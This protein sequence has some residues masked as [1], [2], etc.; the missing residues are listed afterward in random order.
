M[1]TQT[2]A[3]FLDYLF[4]FLDYLFK[5]LDYPFKILDTESCGLARNGIFSVQNL[6]DFRET[7]VSG[8]PFQDSGLPF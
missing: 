6:V 5:I 2:S 8:L 7:Q 1:K 4:K 3:Q